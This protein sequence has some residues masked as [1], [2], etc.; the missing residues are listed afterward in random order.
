MTDAEG[1]VLAFRTRREGC[2][3]A[4]LFDRTQGI[5]PSR[6]H[7]VRVGLV[8]HVPDQAVVRGVE[9]VVQRDGQFDGAEPRREMAA[10]LA[11]RVDQVAAQLVGDRDEI[12]TWNGPQ[13][14]RV[15]DLGQDWKVVG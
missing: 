1:V 8:A 12:A 5:A 15:L 6:E 2:E 10:P 9:H 3:A 13:V 14:R 11:D 7:L 4:A